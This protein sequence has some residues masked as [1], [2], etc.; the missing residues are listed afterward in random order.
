MKKEL[1]K[2][3]LSISPDREIYS[4]ANVVR[5]YGAKNQ[6]EADEFKTENI[7]EAGRNYGVKAR[8]EVVIVI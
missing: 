6:H 1:N 2:R 3:G 7:K 4:S 8:H 5:K